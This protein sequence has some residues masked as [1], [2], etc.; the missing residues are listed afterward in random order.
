M[1]TKSPDQLAESGVAPPISAEQTAQQPTTEEP[2]V[3]D[4]SGPQQGSSQ[5]TV[6]E[7]VVEGP[8]EPSTSAPSARPAEGNTSVSRVMEQ[9]EEQQPEVR[10]QP[11]F[12]D[13]ETRGKALVIAEATDAGLAPRPKEEP[14]EDEVEEVLGRPQDKRQHVYVL[15]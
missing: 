8:T 5:T 11:T 13:A 10:A 7:Q 12:T 14:K 3:E 2:I 1:S 4:P 6:P 9:T 15:S